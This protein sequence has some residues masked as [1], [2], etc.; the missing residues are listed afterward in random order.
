M[1]KSNPY[2]KPEEAWKNTKIGIELKYPIFHH[3]PRIPDDPIIKLSIE[4]V[5]GD[6]DFYGWEGSKEDR[7]VDSTGKVFV[8][9][10]EKTKGHILFIIPSEI[11]SGIFPG[12]VE[13]IM[14]IEEIKKIM[15]SGIERSR[16]VIKENINELKTKINLM[17]SI[18]NILNTCG[19]YF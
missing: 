12:E 6:I 7:I 18:E 16:D 15:I 13:R 19:K 5:M 11:H 10:F 14:E 3:D 17:D 8:A 9:K 2:R 1:C 4:E